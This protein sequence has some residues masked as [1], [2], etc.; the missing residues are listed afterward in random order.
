M[1]QGAK[2]IDTDCITTAGTQ[3]SVQQRFHAW[4]CRP[5]ENLVVSGSAFVL[6]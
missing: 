5:H 1:H 4:P 2:P 3:A 6:N